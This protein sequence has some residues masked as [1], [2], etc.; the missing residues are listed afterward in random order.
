MS[1]VAAA[2]DGDAGVVWVAA[3][4]DVAASFAV[5]RASRPGVCASGAGAPLASVDAIKARRLEPRSL[6]SDACRCSGPPFNFSR[7]WRSRRDPSSRVFAAPGSAS[8]MRSRG[9]PRARSGAA[10]RALCS[11]ERP[12]VRGMD[13]ANAP[14][15]CATIAT[16]AMAAASRMLARAMALSSPRPWRAA[17]LV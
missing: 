8:A 12:G 1:V 4:A 13:G 11:R 7:M 5:C 10:L 17:F 2:A 15:P 3:A 6:S 16:S 9:R 14:A